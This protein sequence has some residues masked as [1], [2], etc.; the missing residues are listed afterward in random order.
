MAG[1][2]A[3][4]E[5][6]KVAHSPWPR[7]R[8]VGKPGGGFAADQL[9]KRAERAGEQWILDRGGKFDEDCWSSSWLEP[10]CLW[11]IRPDF[12][13]LVPPERLRC[14]DHGR[15][16]L[17]AENRFAPDETECAEMERRAW[18]AIMINAGIPSRYANAS[19]DNAKPTPA[20]EAM[21][22]AVES[23]TP[24][25]TGLIGPT[26]VGKTWALVAGF[27]RQAVW[28]EGGNVYFPAAALVRALMREGSDAVLQQCLEAEALW[29]DDLGGCYVKEGGVSESGIEEIFIERE[30]EERAVYFTSN[31]T[32]TALFD[33]LGDRVADRLRGEWGNIVSLPGASLRRKPRPRTS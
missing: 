29:I 7:D 16:K 30:A 2:S 9:G 10:G 20:I 1:V 17:P 24:T 26:G 28:G 27:R 33:L 32:I 5:P 14:P 13:W 25:A 15:L 22:A 3:A 11:C 8:A 4:G 18:P 31:L 12:R 21:R 19:F 23:E 6:Q